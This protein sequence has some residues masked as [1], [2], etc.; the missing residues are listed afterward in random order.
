MD[1]Q[2]LILAWTTGWMELYPEKLSKMARR[3]GEWADNRKKINAPDAARCGGMQS[4]AGAELD[5]FWAA[6]LDEKSVR[7]ARNF[8]PFFWTYFSQSEILRLIGGGGISG[9][10]LRRTSDSNTEIVMRRCAILADI[11]R[12]E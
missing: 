5:G 4:D 9:G 6:G 3:T 10:G 8:I 12:G 2:A 1:W 11:E 7:Q